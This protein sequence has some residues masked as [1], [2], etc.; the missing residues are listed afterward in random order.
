MQTAS[1]ATATPPIL[2]SSQN[3]SQPPAIS[4]G[5][6]TKQAHASELMTNI[7]NNQ[8]CSYRP[9]HRLLTMC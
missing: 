5:S 1:L 8:L 7:D 4:V 9:F 6:C 3:V 2:L